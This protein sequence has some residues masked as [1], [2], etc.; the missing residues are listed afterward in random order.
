MPEQALIGWK[1]IAEMFCVSDRTLQKK[2][3]ELM[4]NGVIFQT[5]R[6]R[7]PRKQVCAFPSVILHY[8]AEKSAHGEI[9]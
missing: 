2:R 1:A 4:Q 7:P 8:L 3:N 5:I 9:I 6:G